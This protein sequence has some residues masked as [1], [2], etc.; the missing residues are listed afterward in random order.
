M[1]KP[2]KEKKPLA[3]VLYSISELQPLFGKKYLATLTMLKGLNLPIRKIGRRCF[4]YAIDIQQ[5]TPELWQ[6]MYL[7]SD[8]AIPDRPA[9]QAQM[10][11]M[12]DMVED[13]LPIQP[14]PQLFADLTL[15][16]QSEMKFPPLGIVGLPEAIKPAEPIIELPI[17]PEESK[18]VI[19]FGKRNY[20][21]I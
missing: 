19:K 15:L 11:V 6:S 9:T 7:I 8:L 3:K 17:Q 1:K 18:D 2:K 21:K 4:V 16:Q 13:D 5:N 14:E 12:P 10:P 20:G